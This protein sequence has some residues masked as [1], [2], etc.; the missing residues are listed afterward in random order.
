ML[1]QTDLINLREEL[2]NELMSYLDD[3]PT[4]RKNEVCAIIVKLCNIKQVNNSNKITISYPN[5]SPL[6]KSQ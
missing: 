5:D 3:L 1:M 2:Q 4:E 6:Y